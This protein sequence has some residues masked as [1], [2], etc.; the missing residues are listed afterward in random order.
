MSN[1]AHT[2]VNVSKLP[3]SADI[4]MTS[5][6]SHHMLLLKVRDP[7]NQDIPTGRNMSTIWQRSGQYHIH[8]FKYSNKCS[9]SSVICQKPNL[10]HHQFSTQTIC[11]RRHLYKMLCLSHRDQQAQWQEYSVASLRHFQKICAEIQQHISQMERWKDGRKSKSLRH[12]FTAH[13]LLL[14]SGPRISTKEEPRNSRDRY[15]RETMAQS[16]CW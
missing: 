10:K 13:N 6:I 16:R 7:W 3:T 2:A 11:L 14:F 5:T 8:R 4:V 1:S 9:R 12:L 15:K